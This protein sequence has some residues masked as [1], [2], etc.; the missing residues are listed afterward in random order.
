MNQKQNYVQVIV[1]GTHD[2][3]NTQGGHTQHLQSNKR[4]TQQ[5]AA[6]LQLNRRLFSGNNACDAFDAFLQNTLDTMC[7]RHRR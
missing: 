4:H 1:C 3:R 2:R 7:K 5:R 6:F